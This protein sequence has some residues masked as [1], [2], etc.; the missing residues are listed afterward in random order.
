MY[1]IHLLSVPDTRESLLINPVNLMV[2]LRRFG[3]TTP[4]KPLEKSMYSRTFFQVILLRYISEGEDFVKVRKF[5]VDLFLG[6]TLLAGAHS[7][8][9]HMEKKGL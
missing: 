9:F 3:G 5:L 1:F 6:G 7:R 4:I 8:V 2:N